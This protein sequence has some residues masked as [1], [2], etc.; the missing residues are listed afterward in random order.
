MYWK[1]GHDKITTPTVL[2]YTI[3]ESYDMQL[4]LVTEVGEELISAYL[5][6]ADS[7]FAG[8]LKAKRASELT[9]RE[10]RQAFD[11]E[12]FLGN[13]SA[14]TETMIDIRVELPYGTADGYRI[15][16]IL[17]GYGDGVAVPNPLFDSDWPALWLGEWTGLWAEDW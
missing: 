7:C 17:I 10:I 6:V 14:E 12:C 16:P 3:G 9:Y 5:F 2:A 1:K 8:L 11:A 13:V 15:V 4:T